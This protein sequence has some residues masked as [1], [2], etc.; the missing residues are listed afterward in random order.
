V[1]YRYLYG[2]LYPLMALRF[3]LA[4]REK[5]CGE[6]GAWQAWHYMLQGAGEA[7]R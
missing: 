7:A 2:R 3:L 1:L 4:H 6:I 5:M